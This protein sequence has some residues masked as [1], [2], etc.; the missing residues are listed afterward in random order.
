[1]YFA[2]VILRIRALPPQ[3]SECAWLIS[4]IFMSLNLNP[5]CSTLFSISPGELV[6]SLLMRI[7]P[8]GVVIRNDARSLLP[9]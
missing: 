9:T 6:R 4:R 2:C 1:M 3:W 7:S 5:S 8:R